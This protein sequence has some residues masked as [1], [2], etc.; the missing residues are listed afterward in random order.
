M[1]GQY[2][3][4]GPTAGTVEAWSVTRLPFEP[5]GWLAD[6]REELRRA[7]RS[8]TAAAGAGHT[9][10]ATYTSADTTRVDVENVL[11]YNVGPAVFGRPSALRMER[12]FAWSPSPLPI[13]CPRALHH[14]RY[15]TARAVPAE[16]WSATGAVVSWNTGPIAGSGVLTSPAKVW[17]A[18]RASV[19]LVS[20]RLDGRN[21]GIDI[22][23]ST[24]DARTRSLP[25]VTKTV[26][27]GFI[28]AL[29]DHDGTDVDEIAVRVA[30]R[31]GLARL[32]VQE[33]LRPMGAPFGVRRLLHRF[34]EGVQWN[35]ADDLCVAA[36]LKL[37]HKEEL[38]LAGRVVTLDGPQI[39][40]RPPAGF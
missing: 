9:L 27:D 10:A 2:V 25:A 24:P 31:S 15:S 19:P 1:P 28:A 12:H 39:G 14:H 21:F 17:A 4:L 13:D 23:I 29:H 30:D 3:I 8:L 20:D 11:L 33:L 7:L 5:R 38:T 37:R 32:E 18:V 16:A 34:R 26:L 40:V 6:F 35:P 36:S 22:T